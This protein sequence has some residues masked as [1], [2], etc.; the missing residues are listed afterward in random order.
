MGRWGERYRAY[1]PLP[2]C[3][4]LAH[5]LPWKIILCLGAFS[6]LG[7]CQTGAK[8]LGSLPMEPLK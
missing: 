5:W 8:Y 3:T 7:V 1:D 6:C 4:A 2:C